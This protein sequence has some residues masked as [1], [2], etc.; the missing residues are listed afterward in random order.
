MTG[1][2]CRSGDRRLLVAVIQRDLE[3]LRAEVVRE[4]I[5]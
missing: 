4:I 2:N 5:R 1:I 3:G